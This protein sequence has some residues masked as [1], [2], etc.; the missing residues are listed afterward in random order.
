MKPTQQLHDLGQSLWLDNITR[1][2]CGAQGGGQARQHGNSGQ[3]R[4]QGAEDDRVRR[5]NLEE[6][7]RQEPGQCRGAE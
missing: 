4:R 7:C 3:Q 5:R 1:R 2:Q 6:H